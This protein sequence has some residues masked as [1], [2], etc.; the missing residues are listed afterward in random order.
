M[1]HDMNRDGQ[2]SLTMTVLKGPGNCDEREAVFSLFP[3]CLDVLLCFVRVHHNSA[4][5]QFRQL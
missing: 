2:Q 1:R 4:T 3:I 5:A